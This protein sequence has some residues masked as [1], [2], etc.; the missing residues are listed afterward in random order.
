MK[1]FFGKEII[2]ADKSGFF[3]ETPHY[4]DMRAIFLAHFLDKKNEEIE[5]TSHIK[6]MFKYYYKKTSF[7]RKSLAVLLLFIIFLLKPVWCQSLGDQIS[8]DCSTGIDGRQYFVL[9]P[10]FL[11]GSYITVLMFFIMYFLLSFQALKIHYTEKV[12]QNEILKFNL[13]LGF[14][15]TSILINILELMSLIPLTT[16]STIFNIL[17]FFFYFK[18]VLRAVKFFFKMISYSWEVLLLWFANVFIFALI[19]RI[20]FENVDIGAPNYLQGYSFHT[21]TDSLNSIISLMFLGGFPDMLVDAHAKS[22]LT[23]LIF[24]PFLVLTVVMI[25]FSISG[26]YYFHFKMCYIET[27]NRVYSQ[28]PEFKMKIKPLLKEKF[29]NPED[30]KNAMNALA[31]QIK[32][33]GNVKKS[34]ELVEVEQKKATIDKLKRVV[35]KIKYIKMFQIKTPQNSFRKTYLEIKD[36]FAFKAVDFCLSLY[37]FIIPI[38]CLTKGLGLTIPENLQTSELLGTL[39]LLDFITTAKF[40]TKE[41]F[42][43]GLKIVDLISSISMII[44]SHVLYLFPIDYRST[45]LIS[46]VF[47]FNCW[48][49]ANF[50][51]LLRI[52]KICLNSIDYKVI[53]KTMFHIIPIVSEFLLIYSLFLIIFSS[54]AFTILGGTYDTQFLE[55]Y[56]LATGSNLETV[57]SFNDLLSSIIGFSFFN[58]GGGFA[59]VGMP[60]SVAF[61]RIS[62]SNFLSIC[63]TLFFYIYWIFSELMIINLIIGLTM[64]FLFAYGDNNAELISKNRNFTSNTNI[65]ER[66]LGL[67]TLEK[68]VFVKGLENSKQLKNENEINSNMDINQGNADLSLELSKDFESVDGA[69]N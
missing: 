15:C 35:Q 51:K 14:F 69:E 39:F 47:F 59:Y 61:A 29:L 26:N 3:P 44:F 21:F 42:W 24:V 23:V 25:G 8:D 67:K 48:A 31:F 1:T 40:S 18:T 56:K 13:L 12:I 11:E 46:S 55:A 37:I 34:K 2:E 16:I 65:I 54:I 28:V 22:P 30:A 58:I 27:L 49:L 17:F 52:H 10:F 7:F 62:Q 68:D 57:Y 45:E 32:N 66:L 50:L 60:A 20:A 19:A 33:E 64:D 5:A 43:T 4:E 41:N 53:I 9:T 6:G 63:L 38:L 36:S